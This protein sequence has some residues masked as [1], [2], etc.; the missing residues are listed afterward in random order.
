MMSKDM[1]EKAAPFYAALSWG[2][3]GDEVVD[4][5]LSELPGASKGIRGAS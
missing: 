4:N 2:F 3:R 1:H 5:D